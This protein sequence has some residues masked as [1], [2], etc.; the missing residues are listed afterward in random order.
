MSIF[1]DNLFLITKIYEIETLQCFS[2]LHSL[3]LALCTPFSDPSQNDQEGKC[4]E[5]INPGHQ[6][7]HDSATEDTHKK[8]LS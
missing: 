3:V 8:Q 6:A 7:S 1:F 2:S 5:L 4:F